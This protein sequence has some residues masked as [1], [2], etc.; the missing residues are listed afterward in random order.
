VA[1]Y[2]GRRYRP[3]TFWKLYPRAEPEARPEAEEGGHS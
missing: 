2:R 3:S 1:I